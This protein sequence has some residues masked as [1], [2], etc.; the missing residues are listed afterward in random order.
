MCP[1]LLK[2]EAQSIYSFES[3]DFYLFSS[4]FHL[5]SSVF[6]LHFEPDLDHMLDIA[7]KSFLECFPPKSFIHL[8]LILAADAHLYDHGT[9]SIMSTIA[10]CTPNIAHYNM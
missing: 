3:I 7:I 9:H 10:S 2:V 6:N 5:L 4:V 1:L 8:I